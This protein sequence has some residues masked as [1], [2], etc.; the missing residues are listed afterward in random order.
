M[1]APLLG[2]HHIALICSDYARAKHFY[3]QILGA[4]I[5]AEHHRAE[6]H[7]H[8]LDLCLPDGKQLELFSFA[9]PPP[10]PSYPEACGL[11]HLAFAVADLDRL[12]AY[13]QQHGVVC[14][15][16]R[17]DE[18]TGRRFTFCADPDGLPLEFYEVSDITDGVIQKITTP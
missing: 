2:I 11:R 14:E 16:V 5:L 7:S 9:N 17:R 6:R 15:P 8:K 18:Y 1:P 3:T 4:R 12:I 10:R 13:L